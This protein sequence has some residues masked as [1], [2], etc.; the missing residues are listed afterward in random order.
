MNYTM[1]VASNVV[2][3]FLVIFISCHE[4]GKDLL[5]FYISYIPIELSCLI[6]LFCGVVAVLCVRFVVERK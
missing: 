6:D 1:F 2:P 4:S 5:C 3:L